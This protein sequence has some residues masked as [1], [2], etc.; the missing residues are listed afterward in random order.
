MET[1][2]PLMSQARKVII[3]FFRQC[4]DVRLLNIQLHFI[5]LYL[6]E[7]KQ[8]INKTQHTISVLLCKLYVFLSLLT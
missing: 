2:I 5:V 6:P 1:D 3:D 7:I 4:Y 8:L